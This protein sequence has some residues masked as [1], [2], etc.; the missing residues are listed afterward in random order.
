M[1]Q[2]HVKQSVIICQCILWLLPQSRIVTLADQ[3]WPHS[4]TGVTHLVPASRLT[5]FYFFFF[6]KTFLPF[7]RGKLSIKP[8]I[9]PFPL[10]TGLSLCFLLNLH[11][12]M[13]IYCMFA[14]ISSVVMQCVHIRTR[15]NERIHVKIF[16]GLTIGKVVLNESGAKKK[17]KI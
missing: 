6:N 15:A 17:K 10:A 2:G 4:A 1:G 12:R 9:V 3:I 11:S 14:F 8:N 16:S 5:F 13:R 7:A